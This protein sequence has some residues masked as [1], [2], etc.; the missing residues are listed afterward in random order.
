MSSTLVY[1]A[2]TPT[3][4]QRN[5]D[6]VARMLAAGRRADERAAR[7]ARIAKLARKVDAALTADTPAAASVGVKVISDMGKFRLTLLRSNAP[8]WIAAAM[9][10]GDEVEFWGVKIPSEW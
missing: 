8:T 7:E 5:R 3:A 6:E 2:A 4:A 1:V 9:I 10:D